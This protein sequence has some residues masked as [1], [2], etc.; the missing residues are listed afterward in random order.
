M[1]LRLKSQIIYDEWY[2]SFSLDYQHDDTRN[3]IRQLEVYPPD[4]PSHRENGVML[5]GTHIHELGQV[6]QN[7][8]QGHDRYTWHDW[9]DWYCHC[10]HIS[11]HGTVQAPNEGLLL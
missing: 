9:F 1:T 10:T 7:F 5:F 11:I 3:I 2:H 8:P 6:N 4:Y